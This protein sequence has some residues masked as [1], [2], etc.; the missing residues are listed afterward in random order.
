MTDTWRYHAACKGASLEVFFPAARVVLDEARALCASCPV[1]PDC[2]AEALDLRD[3]EGFRGGRT[4]DERRAEWFRRRRVGGQ[5]TLGDVD[6]VP[7]VGLVRRRQALA[8]IGYSL[9]ELAGRLNVAESTVNSYAARARVLRATHDRWRLLYDQ[10]RHTPGGNVKAERAA[11]RA[12]WAPPDA[13]DD[14]TIDDP[15]ARPATEREMSA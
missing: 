15:D 1:R 5:P 6:T 8:C 9:S 14:T 3:V 12:G 11:A 13:W 7:V 2:L 10:L 4:G